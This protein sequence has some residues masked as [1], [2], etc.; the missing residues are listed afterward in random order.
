MQLME[1]FAEG[2]DDD[3]L[4]SASISNSVL[5]SIPARDK[6]NEFVILIVEHALRIAGPLRP[7]ISFGTRAET[8]Q[9]FSPAH[10]GEGEASGW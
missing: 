7:T 1:D 6:P 4:G 10:V 2:I 8:F 5:V 3:H 9:V